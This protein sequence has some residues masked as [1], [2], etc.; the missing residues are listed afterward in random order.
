[1]KKYVIFILSLLIMN[2]YSQEYSQ[3]WPDVNYADDGM[4]YHLLDIYLPELSKP[5]YPVVVIIY[6]S[7]WFGNNL[8]G[9]EMNTLGSALLDAGYAVVTPNH[10]ASSDSLFPAQIHDIKAAV[11][12]LRANC[13]MYQL[14]TSFIGITGSSSGGHLAVLA[15]T[16]NNVGEFTVD[17]ITMDLDGNVGNYT[18]FSS[19]VDAVCDWFG[20]TGFLIMDSCGSSMNHDA[21]DSPESSLIGGAIQDHPVLCSLANPVTYVDPTD[22]P[23]LI[24]HGDADPLVPHCESEVL[25]SALQAAGVESEFILVPGGQH[26]TGSPLSTHHTT[27]VDFFNEIS[28]N[29]TET[30]VIEPGNNFPE[31]YPNP[32]SHRLNIQGFSDADLMSYKIMDL[33]GKVISENHVDNHQI[34]VAYL[35]KGIYFIMIHMKEGTTLKRNFIKI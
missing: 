13:N 16:S 33:T 30:S 14:D 19:E 31:V 35:E 15:G 11:R 10:R 28:G 17:T 2:C 34:D 23:F 6:G 3:K 27:M 4:V 18:G 8:K 12:F 20:P 21:S 7:A 5:A 22:P 25:Y 26:S 32:V 1:M 24:I 29:R 9:A